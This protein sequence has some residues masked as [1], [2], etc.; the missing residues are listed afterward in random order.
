MEMSIEGC[1]KRASLMVKAHSN[2]RM[3]RVMMENG[4]LGRRLDMESG[5]GRMETRT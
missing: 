3:G 4:N 5:M 1:I 2:G